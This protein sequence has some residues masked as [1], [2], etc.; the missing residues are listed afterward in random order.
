MTA[1]TNDIQHSLFGGVSNAKIEHDYIEIVPGLALQST[2]AH[3]MSPYMMAFSKPA[4]PGEH[5]PAPWKAVKGGPSFDVSLQIFL[6]ENFRPTNFNRINTIWWL[7]AL[8]RLHHSSG[9]R[10]PVISNQSFH[11]V[12]ENNSEPTFWPMEIDNKLIAFDGLKHETIVDNNTIS[13]LRQHFV[14]TARLMENSGFNLAFRALSSSHRAS[15]IGEAMLLIWSA[16]E[17]LFRPG[18]NKITHKLSLAVATCIEDDPSD[19]DKT[20]QK[21]RSLYAV[22]GQISHAAEKPSIE[23]TISSYKIARKCFLKAMENTSIPDFS[24]LEVKWKT[25]T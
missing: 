6:E 11:A 17:A 12:T 1:R 8:L 23:D 18:S 15:S 22:R 2:Y 24:N 25:R 3:V 20:Y 16:I 5:H 13:W 19:R 21:V 7:F 10:I 4:N 14:S 9:V